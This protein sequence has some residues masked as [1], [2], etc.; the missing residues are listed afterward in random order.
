MQSRAEQL[1]DCERAGS[2]SDVES[3]P[4][5][6]W[7]RMNARCGCRSSLASGA[8]YYGSTSSKERQWALLPGQQPHRTSKEDRGGEVRWQQ[9]ADS[10]SFLPRLS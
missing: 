4:G 2:G 5:M 9:E 3:T 6:Q 10:A 1:A 7:R 8:R